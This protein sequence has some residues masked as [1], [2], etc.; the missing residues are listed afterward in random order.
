MATATFNPS[1]G[2]G[3]CQNSGADWDIMHDSSAAG[4]TTNYTND[5]FSVG[6]A[7]SSGYYLSRAS[8]PF[9]TSSIP[10]G[11]K[12]TAATLRLRATQIRDE[13]NDG[14]DW[15]NVVSTTVASIDTLSSSDYSKIGDATNSPTEL[16]TRKDNGTMSANN[17]YT[18]TL[19][20]AGRS[21]INVGVGAVTKLGLRDG[22]DCLDHPISSSGD[23]SNQCKFASK[24]NSTSAYRPLLTVTY[25]PP[26][27]ALYLM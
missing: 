3:W 12:I 13:D 27:T 26:N 7:H 16:S 5:Y 19:N 18:W 22:F 15:I 24:E 8:I 20:A 2:D 14:N 4:F 17:Y 11:S 10:A 21:E 25:Q 23:V 1:A 9:D 6:S